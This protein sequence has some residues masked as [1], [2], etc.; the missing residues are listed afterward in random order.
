MNTLNTFTKVI[1]CTLLFIS[2]SALAERRLADGHDSDYRTASLYQHNK[3]YQ[4][5]AAVLHARNTH[6]YTYKQNWHAKH[7]SKHHDEHQHRGHDNKHGS[8]YYLPRHPS[9]YHARQ[10]LNH[11]LGHLSDQTPSLNLHFRF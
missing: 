10:R 8:N 7:W 9:Y 4:Q 6:A 1:F 3:H 2:T 11:T 5:Y